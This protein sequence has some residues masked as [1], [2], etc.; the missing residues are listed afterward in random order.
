MLLVFWNRGSTHPEPHTL[1][2]LKDILLCTH[3]ALNTL[4]FS[5]WFGVTMTRVACSKVFFNFPTSIIT[6]QV[7]RYIVGNFANRMEEKKND[8]LWGLVFMKHHEM[9]HEIYIQ[10]KFYKDQ[11]SNGPSSLIVSLKMFLF[12]L[13]YSSSDF[14]FSSLERAMFYHNWLTLV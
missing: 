9:H 11:S 14:F 13:A 7:A 5:E 8:V 1:I 4:L 6:H 2:C 12:C 3:I 10:F